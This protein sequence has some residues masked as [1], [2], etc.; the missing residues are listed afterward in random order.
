MAQKSQININ[1]NR[2]KVAKSGSLGS[3]VE[4]IVTDNINYRSGHSAVLDQIGILGS[5]VTKNDIF[6]ILLSAAN[7]KGQE[8]VSVDHLL[9]CN[10]YTTR[11]QLEKYLDEIVRTGLFTYDESNRRYRITKRGSYYLR[12]YAVTGMDLF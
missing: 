3:I 6:F 2:H 10:N 5:G 12:S 11:K 1:E 9:S 4:V 8:G 7:D